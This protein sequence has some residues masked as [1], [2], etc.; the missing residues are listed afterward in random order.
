[1]DAEEGGEM[2]TFSLPS[3]GEYPTLPEEEAPEEDEDPGP[4][5]YCN[6]SNCRRCPYDAPMYGEGEMADVTL[7][8]D[9]DFGIQ[10]FRRELAKIPGITKEEAERAVKS[11]HRAICKA[12]V[13]AGTCKQT[14]G[15]SSGYAVWDDDPEGQERSARPLHAGPVVRAL[16]MLGVT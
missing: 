10:D 9:R 3:L 11:L 15:K 13:K 16:A 5:L 1:M 2:T 6:V 12:E 7:F 14:V 8:F 4:C